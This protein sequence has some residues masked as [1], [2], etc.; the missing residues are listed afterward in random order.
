MEH[1]IARAAADEQRYGGQLQTLRESIS[2]KEQH[3]EKVEAQMAAMKLCLTFGRDAG[4]NARGWTE[5]A[6]L[7]SA[8]KKYCT[9]REDAQRYIDGLKTELRNEETKLAD[10]RFNKDRNA[11]KW[12]EAQ[13]LLTDIYQK[14]KEIANFLPECIKVLRNIFGSV[15]NLNLDIDLK[16]DSEA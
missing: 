7:E 12:K 1:L 2:A 4:K 15:Y 6:P 16:D 10:I 9:I 14:E 11:N 13:E 3:L 5:K 8:R